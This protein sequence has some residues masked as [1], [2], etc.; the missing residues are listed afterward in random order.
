MFNKQ[1]ISRYLKLDGP[2]AGCYNSIALMINQIRIKIE[3]YSWIAGALGLSEQ[4]A[5]YLEKTLGKGETT[6]DLF[7]ALSTQ[8]PRFAEKVYS[9]DTGRLD[10]RLIAIL[11]KRMMRDTEF[12]SI[13]LHDGDVISLTP[14]IAGG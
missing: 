9:P 3:A 12:S 13:V 1:M 2:L 10:P 6:R 11:N 8:Y 7:I 4:G 5:S 14:I